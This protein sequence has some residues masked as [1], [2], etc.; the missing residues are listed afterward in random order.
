MKILIVDDDADLVAMLTKFLEKHG[1]TTFSASDALVAWD[2]LQQQDIGFLI[3]DLMMPH[4][5]GIAFTERVRKEPRFAEL[6]ILLITA[7]P[8]EGISD[9]GMRKGVAMTLSKP[10]DFERLLTLVRF[11]Q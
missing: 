3:T 9:K 1:F 5:D 10:L 4:M 11:A 6:P 7:Y 8:A 2:L